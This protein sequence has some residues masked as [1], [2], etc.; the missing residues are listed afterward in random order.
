MVDISDKDITKRSARAE[1]VVEL[2]S[3]IVRLLSE[4]DI[5]S[6]KGPVFATAII[7]GTLAAKQ[8][9]IHI[10]FCHQVPVE[11]CKIDIRFNDRQELIIESEVATHH[12]TGVEMEALTA[13]S[14]A[15]LTVYDMCKS[16]SHNIVI[17]NIRLVEKRGEISFSSVV[18]LVGVCVIDCVR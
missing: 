16:M 11:S 10:P 8:T 12:K 2:P 13:V 9:H 15:A 3:Y 4:G 14:L 7:A 1:A 6:K 17:K 18:L 5:Q